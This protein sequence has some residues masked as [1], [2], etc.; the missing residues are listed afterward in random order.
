MLND[1]DTYKYDSVRPTLKT[2]LDE[3][4]IINGMA[5]RR[6]Y[7]IM[8]INNPKLL[9]GNNPPKVGETISIV[10]DFK[11]YGPSGYGWETLTLFIGRKING[12]INNYVRYFSNIK[13]LEETLAGN[14]FEIDTWHAI[15]R[16]TKLQDEI[17]I[18]RQDYGL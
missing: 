1:V 9:E 5:E 11:P 6:K 7:K 14:S 15:N 8:A 16:I 18:I 13:E 2:N 4:L 10:Y 12:R 17:D 3:R